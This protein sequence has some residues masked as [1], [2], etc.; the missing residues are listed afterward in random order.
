MSPRFE[1]DS[2]GVEESGRQLPVVPRCAHGDGKGLLQASPLRIVSQENLQGLLDRQKVRLKPDRALF[3]LLDLHEPDPGRAGLWSSPDA[4][5]RA[6]GSDHPTACFVPSP[7][8]GRSHHRTH[9]NNPRLDGVSP[10]RGPE[11]LRAPA[12]H[13]PQV[14]NRADR[15]GSWSCAW[16]SGCRWPESSRLGAKPP[17]PVLWEGSE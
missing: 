16:T 2:L 8:I 13:P 17:G 10:R 12:P 11:G 7:A 1:D 14:R 3:H 9:H 6:F 4:L 15:L 5:S